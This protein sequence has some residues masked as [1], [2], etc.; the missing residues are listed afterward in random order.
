MVALKV[1][2]TLKPNKDHQAAQGWRPINVINYISKLVDRV[3]ADE[4]QPVYSIK[5][6]MGILKGG[7]L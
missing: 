2:F 3:V 7:W 1:V 4:L 5:T 6:S